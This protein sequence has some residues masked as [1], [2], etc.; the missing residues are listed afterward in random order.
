MSGILLTINSWLRNDHVTQFMSTQCEKSFDGDFCR[1]KKNQTMAIP[2]L[3]VDIMGL[4]VL[5]PFCFHKKIQ[6]EGNI[7]MQ[8]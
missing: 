3:F 4:E 5:Q 1:K 2:F 6:T 8:R 7:N